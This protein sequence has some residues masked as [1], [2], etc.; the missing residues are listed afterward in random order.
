MS[1][2]LFYLQKG[3]KGSPISISLFQF[4]TKNGKFFV[5]TK[6]APRVLRCKMKGIFFLAYSVFLNGGWGVGQ[7]QYIPF[8]MDAV[9]FLCGSGR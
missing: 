9:L 2:E 5:K 6:N 8:F 1:R 3:G 7:F 4:V